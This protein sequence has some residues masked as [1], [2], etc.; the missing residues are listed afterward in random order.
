ME[1]DELEGSFQAPVE[2]FAM[3][4]RRCSV[5]V[6]KT[7]DY[8]ST[9]GLLEDLDE[10]QVEDIDWT[11]QRHGSPTTDPEVPM[12]Y[13]DGKLP[14]MGFWL[15]QTFDDLS[16]LGQKWHQRYSQTVRVYEKWFGVG[17]WGDWSGIEVSVGRA[18]QFGM[19]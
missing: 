3:L 10:T 13:H 7:M 14:A 4:V 17:S 9:T 16:G 19:V 8:L 1:A 15:P 11:V 6:F 5:D 2:W 18:A 12:A